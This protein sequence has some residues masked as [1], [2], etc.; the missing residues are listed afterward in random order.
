MPL[1]EY[2]CR[3]CGGRFE[4]MRKTAER[5]NG[6]ECPTCASA[7]TMLVMSVTG[8]VGGSNAHALAGA[9]PCEGGSGPCCGGGGCMH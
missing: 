6:P 8:K 7:E 2:A 9:P 4:R 5:L 1:Y 3:L